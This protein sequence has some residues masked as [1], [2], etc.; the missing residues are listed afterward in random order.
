[1]GAN[2]GDYIIAVNDKPTNEMSNIYQALVNTAG[3]QVVLKLN[4]EPREKGSREATVVPTADEAK[5]YYY[6]WVQNNIKKV[7]DATGGKVGYVHVPDMQTPGLDEFAKYYYPQLR[8]KGLIIDVR[9]NGG[10]NVSPQLIERLR[11]EIAMIAISRDTAPRPEPGGL[12]DGPMVCLINEFSASDGDIFPYRFRK[13][14]LGKLVGKRTWGGVVGIRNTLPLLD[15]GSLN[16]PE[17]S[18]YDLE[19]KNWI[20]EG[21]GVE[22]DIV[23]DNDP[24]REY[25]GTDDQLNKAIEIILAELKTKEK[26]IP[27]P[28]PY[29]KR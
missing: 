21:H 2:E 15:G 12:L 8:K 23:V 18:R 22:P 6:Q 26:K 16:K 9:G 24:A 3:K 29:P 14:K 1:V 4:S 19:G 17:F 25:A 27:A 7:N 10:G 11:R 13:Y 28:P 20:I 5:L